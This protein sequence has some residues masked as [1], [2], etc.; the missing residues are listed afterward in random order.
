MMPHYTEF[1]NTLLVSTFTLS[2][3][4]TNLKMHTAAIMLS[5]IR[6]CVNDVYFAHVSHHTA[7]QSHTLAGATDDIVIKSCMTG[8]LRG[9]VTYKQ[10]VTYTPPRGVNSSE[11]Y[12]GNAVPHEIGQVG[13]EINKDESVLK[14]RGTVLNLRT[15]FIIPN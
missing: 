4:D 3:L 2:T 10:F 7:S 1:H 6:G 15:F 11:G 9:S 5:T 12:S 8:T 13:Y 14:F